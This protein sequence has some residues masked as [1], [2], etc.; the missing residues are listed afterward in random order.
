M[1][2]SNQPMRM[3]AF[4][5][6]IVAVAACSRSPEPAAPSPAQTDTAAQGRAGGQGGRG[7]G[8]AAQPRAYNR[9]ITAEARSVA[10]LFKAHRI[11]DDLFFEIPQS[12]FG[13]DMLI[14]GRSRAFG[15][16]TNRNVF[17]RFE[18]EGNR[19]LLRRMAYNQTADPSSAIA[20]A[21]EPIRTGGIIASFNVESWG[22]DSAAVIDAT[23]LFTSNITELAGIASVQTDRSFIEHVSAYPDV[24]NVEAVQTANQ[25]PPAA[26]GRGGRGGAAAPGGAQVAVSVPM[27]YSIYKL[28]ETPMMPR[29]HD[30]RV[31]FNSITYIDFSRPEHRAEERRYI[32]RFKLEKRNPAAAV[33]DPVE[34]IIY[35]IDPATPDWLKPWIKSGIE[36]WQPAF[37]EAGF[38]NAILGL[39][40]PADDPDWRIWDARHSII[41]W[42]PSGTQNATGGQ[43]VDPRSG[44]IIKGEVNMFH[45]VQ[46]LLRNWY[47]TQVGPLDPR[48]QNLPLP[49]S[50]M[51]E[52]VEYVVAHEVGHSIGYPHN[53]KAS[54]MYPADSI[55]SEAFLRRMGGHVATL[56]DYSRFN[57]VVQPEDN[58]PP[59][60]LI[61]RVG[62]YDKFVVM[63]GHK[64]IPGAHTPDEEWATLDQWSR[65]QDTVPWF[66]FT[67]SDS[68]ND[69][70]NLTEAVGDEDAVK[71]SG[72]G[73]RNLERVA[74]MLIRVAERPG[75]DY[76]L[77]NELYG[78]IVSQWGRY[79]G[80]V[81]AIVGSAETQERYG[82]GPRFA[83]T[84]KARQ[85]E[86]LAYLR[87]N[88]FLVPEFLLD[89]E[90]LF[91]IQAEGQ[92]ARIRQAQAGVINGLFNLNRLN[93]LI[94]YEAL[95]PAGQS[96]TIADL[97]DGTRAG[98]WSELSGQN[99][100][101]NVYRRNLQRAYI[102][103][104][105]ELV[106]PEE[107]AA[108]APAG[109]GGGGGGAANF[110]SDVRP[111]MRG[112]LVDLRQAVQNA[113]GRAGDAMTRLHLR[114]VVME[115]DRILGND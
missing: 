76:S 112:H 102:E 104:I 78:N 31:G 45:N 19:I 43:T 72:L 107:P 91:R 70:F 95:M 28:T 38:S 34:P 59:E 46:N 58:I 50:L 66:R 18:R 62:P 111:A 87:Q 75:K 86:A 82:T 11:G 84:T 114:D 2:R 21:V 7:G 65:M 56:M 115:I 23:R 113:V 83:P 110:I 53:M 101:I 25:A 36:A 47:F 60:L 35:Y 40:P 93:R 100:R 41:Y 4:A 61:P 73:M 3:M 67:T 20:Q 24:V 16:G 42:R 33:S 90:I 22:P 6:T 68:P 74:G 39:N 79:N 97:L 98:V 89:D 44:Q 106:V 88:A 10:G 105:E 49:D 55:R 17:V 54:A 81:A 71:S 51:G 13:K 103:A 63:W 80:H 26:G 92:V 52:L 64:P 29:L 69:P 37:E 15:S 1:S 27:H 108:E 14:L 96:Y 77:L 32:R 5:V 48:V 99:I 9:V 57:Y 30:A 85:V 8:A 94:E 109:G 12:E